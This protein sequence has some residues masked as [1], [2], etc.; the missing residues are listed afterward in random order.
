MKTNLLITA[1]AALV[2]SSPAL[3]PATNAPAAQTSED[4]ANQGQAGASSRT[5]TLSDADVSSRKLAEQLQEL[6]NNNVFFDFDDIAIKTAY[7]G[8]VLQHAFVGKLMR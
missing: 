4:A 2:L 1:F 7:R 3:T 8:V 6:Q 5:G